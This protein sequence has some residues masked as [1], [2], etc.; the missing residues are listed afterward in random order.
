MFSLVDWEAT[1]DNEEEGKEEKKKVEKK[2]KPEPSKVLKDKHGEIVINTLDAYI[3]PK[4]EI[5]E[6]RGAISIKVI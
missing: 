6:A 5:K 2:P 1:S 4:K 3:E